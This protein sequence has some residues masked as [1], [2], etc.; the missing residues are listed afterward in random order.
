MPFSFLSVACPA[1]IPVFLIPHFSPPSTSPPHLFFPISPLS[2]NVLPSL[3]PPLP[4][5]PSC[6]F[7]SFFLPCPPLHFP[8][9]LIPHAFSCSSSTFPTLQSFPSH[10]S[11]TASPTRPPLIF[12]PLGHHSSRRHAPPRPH[13]SLQP[14]PFISAAGEP[15]NMLPHP[16]LMFAR[17]L[18]VLSAPYGCFEGLVLG[19]VGILLWYDPRL[20]PA[21]YRRCLCGSLRGCG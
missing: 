6:S 9:T 18:L 1:L 17:Q 15:F 8:L 21:R 5:L 20:F 3:L 19:E 13:V 14:W 2:S 16:W 4:F 10:A 12:P 7:P 11:L